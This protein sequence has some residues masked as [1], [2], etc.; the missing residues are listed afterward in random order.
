MNKYTC[1]ANLTK[2]PDMK[3]TQGGKAYVKLSVAVNYG[4]GDNKKTSFLNCVAFDKKAE[5]IANYT[6]KGS[7]VL[8]EGEIVTDS[9][10]KKDN[11][12][13]VYTTEILIREIE[14]LDKKSDG[15]ATHEQQVDNGTFDNAFDDDDIF[16]PV[17]DE[18]IPF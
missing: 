2:D 12:G 13:K 15:Q 4:W 16:Q 6:R 8:I 14:F 18:E 17:D 9:Y 11:S 1:T 3:Y 10:D 7:K 5:A